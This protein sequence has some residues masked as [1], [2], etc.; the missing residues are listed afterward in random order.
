MECC[1]LDND[2]PHHFCKCGL[3]HEQCQCG[4][5]EKDYRKIGE[6]E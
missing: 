1:I 6:I 2:C 3:P 4:W 5:T